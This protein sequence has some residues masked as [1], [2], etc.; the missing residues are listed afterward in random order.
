MKQRSK[1]FFLLAIF[2]VF[3]A[4]SEDSSPNDI[5]EEEPETPLPYLRIT[6]AEKQI[7]NAS[8]DF[9]II[10]SANVPWSA[11]A[12]DTSWLSLS[13]S[14]GNRGEIIK[15][16]Y[17]ENK[18]V[19]IRTGTITFSAEGVQAVTM[20][21]N[22]NRLFTNPIGGI[23]DPWIVK[24]N[25]YYYLCKANGDGIN[26]S[27]SE[28]LTV[29]NGTT[30][31]W[32]APVDNGLIKPW[33][34]THIWAPELHQIDGVWYIYYTAGRPA[35]ESGGHYYKQ[36]S[37]VLRAKTEDPLGSWE[38][39]GMLYTGD[40]Y[41]TG[42]TAIASNTSYAI[43]FTAFRLNNK[44]YAV[45]SGA[46]GAQDGDQSLYI[47]EMINP[48][49]VGSNRVRISRADQLWEQITSSRINEG[50]ATLKH[51]NKLFVVYSCNGSWTKNYRLG[52][53]MLNDTLKNPLVA[54]N[55]EKSKTDVFYRCDETSTKDGV[56]GVGHCSF[57]KSPD[58][59]ED[60]IV[61]HVKN[62]NDN[63]YETGRSTFIKKFQWKTDGTPDFGIPAGWGE[64]II[65][66][67]GEK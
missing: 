29:L 13:K 11:T 50:P 4:C 5:V 57:T 28:K 30:S 49:T 59:K 37:G 46:P 16:S 40:N 12:S 60:W 52:F 8:G 64:Q 34:T 51:N 3:A 65:V 33:N 35:S 54:S 18:V 23:P 21:I 20:T 62:R 36:R 27:K 39:L 67:S 17:K 7:A 25:N 48:Y 9:E 22:Q 45:W 31:V 26:I 63:T 44:L 53:I 19:E 42:I 24:N 56:N 10:I 43:D 55:W 66:P 14:S 58:E 32:R 2:V 38:D 47:A 41:A 6:P 15:V 1:H 61:Y